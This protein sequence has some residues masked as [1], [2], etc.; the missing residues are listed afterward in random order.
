[1]P[2]LRQGLGHER[3]PRRALT[4]AL[5]A[6]FLESTLGGKPEEMALLDGPFID[7]AR[8]ANLLLDAAEQATFCAP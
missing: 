1:V 5:A 8:A 2:G 7:Q 3:R 4:R 6:A